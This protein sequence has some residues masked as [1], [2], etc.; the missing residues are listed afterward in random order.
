MIGFS[1]V[2]ATGV[3]GWGREGIHIVEC[4][5]SVAAEVL[6]D[7]GTYLQMPANIV[8]QRIH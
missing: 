6:E 3:R 2:L 5:Y 4:C 7:T 8:Q 1:D